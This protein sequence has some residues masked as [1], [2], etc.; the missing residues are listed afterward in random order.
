MWYRRQTLAE[1]RAYTSIDEEHDRN[2]EILTAYVT[3][4]VVKEKKYQEYLSY[5]DEKEEEYIDVSENKDVNGSASNEA[6]NEVGSNLDKNLFPEVSAETS[7]S[8][9]IGLECKFESLRVDCE[10]ESCSLLMESMGLPTNFGPQKKNPK[11][12]V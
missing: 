6:L 1:F 12:K 8:E 10:E 3:R 9:C 11:K 5:F 4:S 7:E 2:V